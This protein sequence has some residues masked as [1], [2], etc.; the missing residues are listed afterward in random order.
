M[1]FHIIPYW[2][3]SSTSQFSCCN[4]WKAES[5]SKSSYSFVIVYSRRSKCIFNDVKIA[6]LK[7]TQLRSRGWPK[8]D[9]LEHLRPT[10]DRLFIN[11]YK[12]ERT[13]RHHFLDT[14]ESISFAQTTKFDFARVK[15]TA[16]T[17]R[18]FLKKNWPNS[19]PVARRTPTRRCTAARC[20]EASCARQ[21]GCPQRFSR[22]G[23]V[24]GWTQIAGPSQFKNPR[25]VN[26][27]VLL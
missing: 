24:R 5:N 8:P 7:L 20:D 11:L 17:C 26:P 22:P 23:Q 13:A 21:V 2:I 12:E 4:H 27:W 10:S 3:Y 6:V 25:R 9:Q 15:C 1:R 14:S 16:A 19:R 18:F